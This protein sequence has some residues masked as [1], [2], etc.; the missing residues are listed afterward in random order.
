MTA[1]GGD[2]DDG[3]GANETTTSSWCDLERKEKGT[4]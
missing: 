1:V 3:D 4:H 2:G